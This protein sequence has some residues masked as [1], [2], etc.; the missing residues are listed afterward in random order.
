M[1]R[2]FEEG[3]E[4]EANRQMECRIQYELIQQE[5]RAISD[6]LK[7]IRM[8]PIEEIAEVLASDENVDHS[9][10]IA[11]ALQD[12]QESLEDLKKKFSKVTNKGRG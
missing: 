10:P 8:C 12:L 2:E 6:R 3:F 5:L 7:P 11:G 9:H 4:E 1:N